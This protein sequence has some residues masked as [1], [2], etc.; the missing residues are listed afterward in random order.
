MKYK[1]NLKRP[2]EH[3]LFFRD[4]I[5]SKIKTL[6]V[7]F[8]CLNIFGCGNPCYF[9]YADL[10]ILN[11]T[12]YDIK[13]VFI[14]YYISGED[15]NEIIDFPNLSVNEQSPYLKIKCGYQFNPSGN[16]CSSCRFIKYMYLSYTLNGETKEVVI[17][18]DGLVEYVI[19]FDA[20]TE[21]QSENVYIMNKSDNI[22]LITEEGVELFQEQ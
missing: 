3:H 8:F 12:S 9:Y 11:E 10:S 17:F 13:N 21:E 6:L 16:G 22:I 5:T 1:N 2:Y 7:M 18:D 19:S 20:L 15:S 4:N 14:E